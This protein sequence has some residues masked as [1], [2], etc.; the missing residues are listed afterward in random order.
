MFPSEFQE[1]CDLLSVI[2]VR[3]KVG[4]FWPQIYQIL[5]QILAA[6]LAM[7]ISDRWLFL[8]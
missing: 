3:S 1:F 4:G 6:W 8:Q 2:L 7:L 5:L